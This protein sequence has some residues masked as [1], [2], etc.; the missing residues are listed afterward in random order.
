MSDRKPNDDEIMTA[1]H[2]WGGGA[3]YV[4]KNTLQMDGFKVE[5]PWVLRQMKRLERLGR[6]E[7]KPTS[8]AVMLSWRAVEE[9]SHD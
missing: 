3:T 6:V 7:R 2:R 8:Y 9:P 4:I 5:T 1:V